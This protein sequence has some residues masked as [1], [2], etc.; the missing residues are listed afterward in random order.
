MPGKTAAP[1]PT[2]PAPSTAAPATGTVPPPASNAP[3]QPTA[4]D[5]DESSG[6]D[7]K[8]MVENLSK[9]AK[10]V[11]GSSVLAAATRLLRKQP[12]LA[13][14]ALAVAGVV[15]VRQYRANRHGPKGQSLASPG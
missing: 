6:F 5:T 11:G 14:A 2:A 15:I 8:P 13:A 12:A 4:V 1:A 9:V 3:V 7:L 10:L